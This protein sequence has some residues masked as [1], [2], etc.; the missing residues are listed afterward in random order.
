MTDLRFLG[1]SFA[2]ADLLLELDSRG[3]IVFATGSFLDGS[4]QDAT[5]LEGRRIDALLCPQSKDRVLQ[6]L[7]RLRE[8]RR[9]AAIDILFQS[10][11]TRRRAVFRAF[12][13]PGLA[14]HVSCSILYSG[15]VEPA[16][17]DARELAQLTEVL[18]ASLAA[19]EPG[20]LALI[21]VSGLGEAI[22]TM[23]PRQGS[24]LAGNVDA[25]VKAAGAAAQ[26][27]PDRFA[28]LQPASGLEALLN[29]LRS[30]VGDV[31]DVRGA[32]LEVPQGQPVA[33][34]RLLRTVLDQFLSD[35][36][37]EDPK[38]LERRFKAGFAKTVR[39]VARLQTALSASGF[40]LHFQP[41]VDL[42]S[43]QTH[44]FEAL[45]RFKDGDSC[46]A[47]IRLAEEM[48]LIGPFDLEVHRKALALVGAH[49]VQIAI[50]LS[51]RTLAD[52]AL[53]SQLIA[54]SASRPNLRRQLILEVTETAALSDLPAAERRIQ[55]LRAA[56]YAVYLDDFGVGAASFDYLRAF[57][58]DGVKL[59]GR[60]VHN[61][62]SDTR[63]RDMVRH[64]CAMATSLQMEVVAEMVENSAT[65]GLLR[66]LGVQYG[67]GW[68]FG[69]PTARLA[70]VR[71]LAG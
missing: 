48:D 63:L 14:P 43:F 29:Q 32:E 9:T 39:D 65:A 3:Q 53:I 31:L 61:V 21:E 35:G 55:G 22:R 24:E 46:A 56:G 70:G 60:F 19:G 20:V 37:V 44:H 28:V 27:S 45:A 68:H 15:G 4:G 66:Q 62:E 51:A 71:R 17:D 25:A 6:A 42:Q 2:A 13:T 52:E 41:V 57:T 30:L 11:A 7:S 49:D 34:L 58:L 33:T 47:T 40:S 64:L 12:L 16:L 1:F 67:Q 59:D 36:L 8:G 26:L 18:A 38:A 69:R 54:E 23:P 50:N 5:A 10:G